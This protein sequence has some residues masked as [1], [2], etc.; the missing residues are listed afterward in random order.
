MT[1]IL[2]EKLSDITGGR[3]IINNDVKSS[4][5]ELESIILQ[6]RKDMGI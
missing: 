6:R 4:A 2:T 1:E 5:D 3:L